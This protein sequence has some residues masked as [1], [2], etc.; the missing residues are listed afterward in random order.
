MLFVG[1]G[2]LRRDPIPAEVDALEIVTW[3]LYTPD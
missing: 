1:K 3:L 2:I